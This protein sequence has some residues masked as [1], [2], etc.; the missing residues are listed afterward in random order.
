MKTI[1]TFV[2]AFWA[3]SAAAQPWIPT[4]CRQRQTEK[5]AEFS[6]LMREA[7]P[8]SSIY[9]PKPYPSSDSQ[10]IEDFEYAYPSML[11]GM[12]EIPEDELPLFQGVKSRSLRYRIRRV[13]NW[14]PSRCW[15]E[16]QND[17]YFLL[18]IFSAV[19]GG[20]VARATLMQSGLIA[21][22]RITSATESFA[23]RDE[24]GLNE[25]VRQVREAFGLNVNS[26]QYVGFWGT[27]YCTFWAPCVAFR[28][29]GKVYLFHR[30]ELFEF[31]ET[32]KAHP[33]SDVMPYRGGYPNPNMPLAENERRVSIGQDHWVV[34][35]KVPSR[36]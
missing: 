17:Y 12:K 34:A 8:G 3:C 18:D 22:W 9:A 30:G 33:D 27:I 28:S 14:E 24:P 15:S 36:E 1:L 4:E 21:S 11:K 19:S 6:R 26:P 10:I 35:R 2:A 25:A 13:E 23:Q 16:Q 7:K 5:W 20:H 31:S 32:A 29:P